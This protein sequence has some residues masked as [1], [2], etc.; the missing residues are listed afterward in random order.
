MFV[1]SRLLT[2]NIIFS[3]FPIKVI[4]APKVLLNKRNHRVVTDQEDIQERN[5]LNKGKVGTIFP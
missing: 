3:L 5:W 1:S 4:V 2:D